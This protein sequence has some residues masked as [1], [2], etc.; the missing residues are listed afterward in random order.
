[1]LIRHESGCLEGPPLALGEPDRE[2]LKF[3]GLAAR[4][5]WLLLSDAP[6]RLYGAR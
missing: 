6:P 5:W 4:I 2:P 3:S 1:M